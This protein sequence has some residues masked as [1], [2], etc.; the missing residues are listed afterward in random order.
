[1]K[2]NPPM[3]SYALPLLALTLSLPASVSANDYSL[4][5][6]SPDTLMFRGEINDRTAAHLLWEINK[7]ITTLVITS[8]GGDF[9]A[10]MELGREIHRRGIAV[11]VQDYC[12]S[13]CANYLFLASPRKSLKPASFL[14]FHGAMSANLSADAE[15]LLGKGGG[16]GNVLID[17]LNES[18]RHEL[19]FLKDT[20]VQSALFKHADTQTGQTLQRKRRSTDP[21]LSGAY[22]IKT[23]DRT[24][25][26][27]PGEESKM[28]EAIAALQR[29]KVPFTAEGDFQLVTG[30]NVSDIAYFPSRA[31]LERYGVTGIER[32]P[33]PTTSASL[34]R[35][36][37]KHIKGVTVTGDFPTPAAKGTMQP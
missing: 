22:V 37:G 2:M 19:A 20:G 14:G 10:G 30:G 15:Q 13:S 24:L 4:T 3:R 21:V 23:G 8:P 1:M 6:S 31:T 11:T 36:V 28:A 25:T 5:R 7:G 18:A 26:F 29:D 27:R 17:Y 35:I 16:S 12:V 32:Y 9:V 33:Y 34:Q